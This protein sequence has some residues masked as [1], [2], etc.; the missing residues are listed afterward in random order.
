MANTLI[1][2]LGPTGV[3]KTDL[4]I[5]IA[6]YFNCEILS[7]DSRQIYREMRVGTAV[8]E[9]KYLNKIKHH[10]IGSQSIFDYYSAAKFETDVL[11]SLP[12]LFAK[13]PVAL[14]TGGS[15]LYIDAVC[16]GIDDIP[17][18]DLELREKLKERMT[19]EGID[20]LRA[21][22]KILDPD[23]YAEVDLKNPKRILHALEIC[24]MTGKPY[25][26][27][28]SNQAKPRE[29]NIVKVGLN[30]ERT[31]LYDRINQRVEQMFDEGLEQEA[32][33]LYPHR[34]LNSLNTVGYR[35]MFDHFDGKISLVEAKEKIQANS[36]KYARKQLTWFRRDQEITWFHPEQDEEILGFLS[37]QLSSA[38]Y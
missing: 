33:N 31:E 11:T 23:Y 36:R 4:S 17:D 21:E 2:L 35:E 26:S 6:E 38:L 34:D 5:R 9:E 7:C 12:L 13:S 8:P 24:F 25:S 18:V 32:L 16:K 1:V 29:F 27:F 15:M 19:R 14:M 28:R 22:L 30:R 10:F 20:S 3:G 37:S